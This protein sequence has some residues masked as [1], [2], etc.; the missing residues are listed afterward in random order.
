MKNQIPL[1]KLKSVTSSMADRRC[2]TRVLLL[3]CVALLWIAFAAA[4]AQAQTL[5]SETTWGG[6]GSDVSEGVATAADGTSYLVGITDSFARDPFGNPSPRIFLVKFAPD[7]SLVWQRIWNGTTVRGLGRTGVALG[8]GDSVYV[9]G[10]STNNGNDA[11]LLKFDVNGNLLWERIWGGP[12]SDQSLAV[13]ATPDGSAYIAGTAT[14]FG[15]SS[16]GLFVVKFDSL[17]NLVWQR[18]S[19][20]AEGN[21]VAVGFDGSVYAAG[22]T[23]RNQIGNFDLLVLKITSGGDLIWQRTYASGEVV[24]PRG[25]MTVASDGS[26]YLAGAIQT[27]KANRADI[28]ALIVKLSTNGDL[29]FDKEFDGRGGETATGIA[30]APDDSTV[31]VAGTTTT[32]GAGSQDAFVLHLPPTGKKL[33]DAVTWGGSGFEEG[34]GV[35]VIAG[36][37]ALSATTTNPPPY[38]L[39]D[40]SARLSGAR[41][42]L[43]VIAGV[44]DL[45]AGVSADPAAGAATPNGSTIFGGNFEAALVRIAR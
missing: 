22:T 29:L 3:A 37:V 19:D 11:V 41:G 32:F 40:A 4:T 26:V 17:G 23:P 39:L 42:T 44:L 12:A 8:A 13:A 28:A 36:T 27:V 5:L 38:S 33:L 2:A 30:V 45:P 7:G 15:P 20:G 18:I 16:S 14:S 25:G 10:V 35:G 31:Y 1:N 34:S 43:A 24:D 6:D 21:A 9:T